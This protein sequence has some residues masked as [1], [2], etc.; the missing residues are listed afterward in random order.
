[1]TCRGLSIVFVF[2]LISIIGNN[3]CAQNKKLQ[4]A[5]DMYYRLAF[6]EAA[7]LYQEIVDKGNTSTE[8]YT[9]LGD[10]YYFNANYN[11]AANSYSK[12]FASDGAIE[13]EY[14]FRYAQALNST[15]KHTE[16]AKVMKSYYSK[17]QK[18]DL[19]DNWAPEKLLNDIKL[20]S[21]RYTI[22]RVEINSSFSDFGT[23]FYGNDKVIYAS[24]KDTG[25]IIKRIHKWNGKA[26]LKLYSA[27]INASG[28]LEKS[29]LLKG[30][31]NTKY[32]QSSPS[33]TKD[34]KTIY[35][36]RNNY[37][38]GKLV[39][40]KESG[41]SY[42]KIYTAQNIDGVWKNVKELS[43]PV[44]GEGFSAAHPALSADESE[45][46]FVSDRNNKFGNSDLYVV[47][48]KKNGVVGSNL[49]KLGNE[50]NTLGTETFPF[51]DGSG[52][53]YFSS[54]GH[55]GLGGLDVFAAAKDAAGVY[56]VINLGDG[57]NTEND[58]FAYIIKNDTRKG[59]FS[60][61]RSGNDDIYGFIE[62]KPPNFKN[63]S[64]E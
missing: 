63:N 58:D 54:D 44:N 27:T 35:F 39:R 36:T 45:L 41:I 8:V 34:G 57:I 26:F 2:L 7:I 49:K 24:A 32:H 38:N 14:Y 42:L 43:F 12:L 40:D 3:L 21:G 59:Y 62:N 22:N 64:Q 15:G 52:I 13:P 16:A 55:P 10:S 1:M 18:K 17:F 61:N 19:S 60:S 25:V 50:I 9:K 4:K 30:E 11:E 33:I 23:A 47:D 5:N 28:G 51:I 46:Y 29:E 53:L 6:A 20:Q 31:L 56:Q 37:A 48:I